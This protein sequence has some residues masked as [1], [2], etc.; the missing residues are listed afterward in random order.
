MAPTRK[1]RGFLSSVYRPISNVIGM[2][3]NVSRTTTQS[4][5]KIVHTSLSGVNKIGKNMTGRANNMIR[6]VLPKSRRKNKNS[7][8]RG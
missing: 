7:R 3:N 2:A 1:R 5:D 6:H 8:R 4:I